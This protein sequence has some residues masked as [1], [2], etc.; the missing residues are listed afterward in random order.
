M[1]IPFLGMLVGLCYIGNDVIVFEGH[2]STIPV[3]CRNVDVVIVDSAIIP[4]M[5]A[6]WLERIRAV[7]NPANEDKE[8]YVHD[9]KKFRLVDVESFNADK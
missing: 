9:R 6:D 8:V 4:L 7:M 1:A 2:E 3:A 5:A